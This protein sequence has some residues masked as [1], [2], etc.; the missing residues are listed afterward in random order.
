VTVA[1]L[2][3][4]LQRR[5]SKNGNP[6]GLITLEDME[7]SVEVMFFGEAY[8]AYSPVL[9]EDAVIAVRGRVRLRDDTVSLQAIEVSLPDTS[10]VDDT[11]VTIALAEDRCT[12][13]VVERLT[14]I[15]ATHPGPTEVH[16]RLHASP[17]R[18]AKV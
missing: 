12:P 9:A 1:G 8:L 17:G 11:P 16:I 4:S 13:P 2:V 15:L 5:M 14:E 3:T 18:P 7:G 6:W 10:A